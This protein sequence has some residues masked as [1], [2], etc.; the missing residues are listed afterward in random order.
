[1]KKPSLKP[2]KE[3][4]RRWRDFCVDKNLED[5]WLERLNK[6]K[7]FILVGICEG[8]S[9]NPFGSSGRYPHLNF[10]LR[11]SLLEGIAE[12]WE[13]LRTA[14]L[15]ETGKLFR[16]DNTN[17][18]LELSF[19]LRAGQGKFVYHEDMKMKVMSYQARDTEEMGEETRGWF[20]A[21]I[22]QIEEIDRVV[23]DWHKQRQGS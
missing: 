21:L 4:E 12:D 15:N 14:M 13:Y 11:K 22:D 2:C 20:V 23:Y 9:N 18:R 17:I 6:L 19:R 16:S 10:S 1:M 3:Y 5:D 7:A 8:H